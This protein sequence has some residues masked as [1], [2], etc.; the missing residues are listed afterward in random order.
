MNIYHT[1]S[2]RQNIVIKQYSEVTIL[3]IHFIRD[4]KCFG[5][6]KLQRAKG[7]EK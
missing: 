4:A 6:Y 7:N 1:I 2:V 3:K 5:Q